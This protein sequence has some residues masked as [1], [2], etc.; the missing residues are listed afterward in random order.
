MRIEEMMNG[1][2]IYLVTPIELREFALTVANEVLKGKAEADR[3]YTPDE[4]AKLHG[5][6]VGT[7]WHW[8]KNGILKVTKIGGRAFYK[9]S[10]LKK[11]VG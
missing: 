11:E 7:L 6:N 8:R 3:L 2:A 9:E 10:D 4:F 5:V 1:Q